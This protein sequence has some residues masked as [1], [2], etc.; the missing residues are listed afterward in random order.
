MALG[1]WLSSFSRARRPSFYGDK[2]LIVIIV[3]VVAVVDDDTPVYSLFP[4]SYNVA[5]RR[6]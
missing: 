2:E 3:I 5:F 6:H 1:K 4:V